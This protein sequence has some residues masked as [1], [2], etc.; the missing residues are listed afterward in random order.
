MVIIFGAS[1]GGEKILR[2][3]I[4]L[5]IDFFV[6]NDSEKWGTMFFGYPVYSPEVIAEQPLKGLKVFVASIFYEEIKK[7]LESFQLIEGIHFYNGLQI[8]EERK[9]F[10]HCVVRLEQYVDTGVKNIEQ[11]LQRRALQET[12]DFV[13]QHLMRVPS[14]PDRYSLLEYALSLAETGGL[15]LEFGVFQGDS[16]NF[17][18]SRV[19]HTVYGFDS[20]AG[21][22]EDWRDGF[23]RG[24]FRIDQLPRVN[25]N[26]QLIQGLFHES[27]PKFLQINHDHCSFIHID[28]DLYSSTRD[29]FHALDER[30]VEGTI[31]VFDEFFNYP[32]WKNGEFKAFQ[33]FVTNNQIEFEYIAYCRYHEQVAVKIKGRSRTS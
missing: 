9:R 23:P 14:F 7:Q 33:E 31:I 27:L 3:L 15:F 22:P 11:E 18:S 19:P 6:D 17:I 20:F 8:V 1:S 29:I 24:A 32:G 2:E 25:D 16:I 26:V 30:I 5:Q 10:R 28:C 4:D 13:E 12:V 21:L